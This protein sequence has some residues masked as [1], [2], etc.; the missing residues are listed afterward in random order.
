MKS[1]SKYDDDKMLFMGPKV[2]QYDSHMI[3]T[4]VSQPTKRKYVNLDTSFRDEYGDYSSDA[5]AICTISLPERIN[6]VKSIVVRNIELPITF[7][8]I[9]TNIGN[10]CFQ[11]ECPSIS[12]KSMVVIPDGEYTDAS[13]IS[14]IN[15]LI[16][17]L[18]YRISSFTFS[19]SGRKTTMLN[20][21]ARNCII[22]FDKLLSGDQNRGSL[23]RSLG[24][25][26]GFRSNAYTIAPTASFKSE[27]LYEMS[28]YRYVYLVLDEFVGGVPNSFMAP[29]TSSL[30][31]KNILARIVINRNTHNFGDWISAN[32]FNGLLLSD[33]RTY[34]G[35]VDLQ[36]LNLRLVDE[37]GVPICMNGSE[38]SLCLEVDYE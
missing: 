14:T 15:T 23:R 24:W 5:P 7:Y 2:T 36:R 13:L 25:L 35:K 17:A 18:D 9:S 26:L 8:N 19:I 21:T 27:G 33:R 30:T 6:N 4:N 11:I 1:A 3:M 22:H 28:A 37:Y 38:Y 32:T 10:N 12:L 29:K 16:G 31:Q 34:S 20:N